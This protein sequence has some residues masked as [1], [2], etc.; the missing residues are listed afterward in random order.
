MSRTTPHVQSGRLSF[1]RDARTYQLIVDTPDWYTWLGTASSFAFSGPEGSFTARRERSSNKRGG[2]YWGRTALSG[3]RAQPCFLF[4]K[5]KKSKVG[6]RGIASDTL[7]QAW[8]RKRGSQLLQLIFFDFGKPVR[9]DFV[10]ENLPQTPNMIGESCSHRRRLF[11]VMMAP[12]EIV[13]ASNQIHSP[14]KGREVPIG[15][16]T[17]AG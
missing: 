8:N 6:R 14:L 13:G 1:Q 2:W 16:P 17:F 15:M 11:Q 10:G 12:T 9:R 3:D 7:G 4:L 5:S